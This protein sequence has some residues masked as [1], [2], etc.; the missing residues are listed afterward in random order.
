MEET[1]CLLLVRLQYKDLAGIVIHNS[2]F[3]FY[4]FNSGYLPTIVKLGE[5]ENKRGN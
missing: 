2:Y 1:V 3:P 4:I 5:R